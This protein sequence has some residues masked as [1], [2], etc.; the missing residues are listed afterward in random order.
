MGLFGESKKIKKLQAQVANLQAVNNTS[1]FTN[2][3]PVYPQWDIKNVTSRYCDTDDVYSIIN[4]ITKASAGIPMYAYFEKDPS[5]AKQL[6]TFSPHGKPYHQKQL[7]TKALEDLPETDPVYDLLENPSPTLS[8]FE[9]LEMCHSLLNLHGECIIWKERGDVR[10]KPIY[11]HPLFPQFVVLKV[12]RSFPNT[13][14][15]YDYIVDGVRVMESIPPEDIIHIRYFNP[16]YSINGTELRGLS[17]IRILADRLT[18]MDNAF[19]ASV[20]QLQNG[21]VSTIVYMEDLVDESAT[22]IINNHKYNFYKFFTNKQN[23]G[24]VYWAGGKMQAIPLGLKLSDMEVAA[25]DKIDFKKLCN[26]YSISD[27][28]FNNDATGSEVSDDN[29]RKALYTDACLPNVFRFAAALQNGLKDDFN[30]KKRVI[31]ADISG[32]PELQDNMKDL[33]AW[34]AVAYWIDP[35]EKREMMKFDRS[36]N[37]TFNEY[38]VPTGLQLLSDLTSVD[39]LPNVANDYNLNTD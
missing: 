39:D 14:I 4:R 18:R 34:L 12:T 20:S 2:S 24:S 23:T 37:P 9:W 29:A 21:G 3:L 27:R 30:D 6:K 8:K 38:L 13:I 11:L 1:L 32:I 7:A 16:N 17:P 33:A 10:S 31:Y 35:N 15:G 28:L 22:T 26:A 25:L 19:D 5:T 36:T